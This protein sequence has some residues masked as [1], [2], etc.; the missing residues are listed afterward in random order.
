MSELVLVLVAF[1]AGVLISSA[2]WML[3]DL[4]AILEEAAARVATEVI[5]GRMGFRD[6]EER[7]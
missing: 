2:V 5:R 4:G 6:E 1:V 3:T 7:K